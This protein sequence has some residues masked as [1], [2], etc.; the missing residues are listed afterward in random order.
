MDESRVVGYDLDSVIRAIVDVGGTYPTV[1][2]FLIEAKRADVLKTRSDDEKGQMEIGSAPLV[3]DALPSG[4]S[5]FRR[6]RDVAEME[7]EIASAAEARKKEEKKSFWSR[8]N[9]AGWFKKDDGDEDFAEM[10]SDDEGAQP[11]FDGGD[12]E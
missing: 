7:R 1:V 10:F 3:F 8:A 2:R 6:V 4:V 11:A 12:A 5:P 9:P